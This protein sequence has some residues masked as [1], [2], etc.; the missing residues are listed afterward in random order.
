MKK[1]T[2]S[3]LVVVLSSAFVMVSAQKTKQDSAKTKSIEEV[4]ITGALGIKK[5]KDAQTSAQQVVKGDELRQA[6]NPDPIL[7][8]QG[9]VSGVQ[10]RQTNSSVDGTNS[11]IIRGKRTITG[12]NEALVVIDNVI[13]TA[14]ALQQLPPDVIESINIIKGAQGSALYGSQ[15]VNGVVVVTTK[16]GARGGRMNVTFNSSVDFESPAYLPKRQTKYGQGWDGDRISV[17]NGAWG[18]AFDDPKYAGKLLPYGIPLYDYN[19]DGKITINANTG[20]DTPD[21]PASIYS[22]FAPYGKDNARD[23]FVN[24]TLYQNTITANVGG[25]N[26]YLLMSLNNT[27]R[28][29]VVDK[30]KLERTTALFKAGIKFDKWSFDGSVN[31]Q[32]SYTSQ[33]T[34]DIYYWL[35]QSSSDI[36][37]TRWKE[38]RDFAYGWNKYYGNPYWYIDNVRNNNSSYFINATGSVGYKINKNIDLLYRGS[39]QLTSSEYKAYNNGYSNVLLGSQIKAIT[40]SYNQYNSQL[41]RYYGDF[42]ANFNYDLTDDLNL[43]VNAGHNYQE[44]KY[45]I[46]TAGGTGMI[47]PQFYQVW[48]LANPT[49]PYNLNN[50][51][52]RYNVHALFANLDLAYKDYL[53]LNATARNEW[54]SILPKNNNSYFFPSV[55]VSFIPTKAFDF[56]GNVLN[57]M[58]IFGNYGTTTSSSAIGTYA[59]QNLSDLGYGFPYKG[60]LSFVVRTSQ[61]DPNIRPE[62]VKKAEIGIALGFL[63]DRIT[64]GGSLYQDDT[65]DLIT[66]ASTSRTSGLTLRTMNIGLLRNRGID[67]DLNIKIFNSKDFKWDI[68]MS[69][70]TFDTNVLKV[71]D[72]TDEVFLGGY[73]FAGVYAKKGEGIILKGTGY[74]RDPQGRIIVNANTGDPLYTSTLE[75]YGKVDPKYKLGF[76]TGLNYKGFQL[77][78]VLEY[79][80]GG[81]FFAGA[82]KGF[83]F[84]GELLESADFDRTKGGFVMPN[85]VYKDAS[86]NYVPNTTVKTGGDNY[87]GVSSYY[88]NVYTNIADNFIIDATVFRIREIAL[89]YS[90]PAEVIKPIGLTGFTI[91][92]HARNPFTKLAKGNDNYNDPDTSFTNGNAQG[93]STSSQ[94][95]VLKSYGVSLNLNF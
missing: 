24:G 28:G 42:I 21:S 50:G 32:K 44:Y 27:Q 80:K 4:V 2:N 41:A 86:G 10:I 29:F 33:T 83:A 75:S 56:G 88:S 87:S 38:H 90:F 30:D 73:T 51:T 62:K 16:R 78:A 26:S 53:F 70:T 68:G 64:F 45:S 7:A 25:E 95:P 19:G 8:M 34:P 14:T 71:T 79:S 37:I 60:D 22:P 61:T 69:L 66:N 93:L 23:F 89:S 9:K 31:I 46:T 55:G 54:S 20:A 49:I 48:N 40:S 39:L 11:I 17:E 43:R 47:I 92:I 85:S 59:I 65:N 94:Y 12:S 1:L 76:T 63:K 58:K 67:A 91:G 84:S 72:D 82:K 6:S 81:K 77:S 52:T 18:P 15:G 74:Q 36:P 13:S 57:Y 3:V 5:S 35:L